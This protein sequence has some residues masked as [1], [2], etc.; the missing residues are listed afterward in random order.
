MTDDP[1]YKRSQLRLPHD[2]HAAIVKAAEENG[3]SMNNEIVHRLERSLA[4]DVEKLIGDLDFRKKFSE[5]MAPLVVQ[6][7]KETL[8]VQKELALAGL[9]KEQITAALESETTSKA[10]LKKAED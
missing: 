7:H 4:G 6:M 2:L 1:T 10:R 5:L 8:A 9:S 3:R